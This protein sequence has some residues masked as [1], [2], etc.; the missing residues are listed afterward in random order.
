MQTF[1]DN[2][3]QG[4]IY[5]SPKNGKNLVPASFKIDRMFKYYKQQE[6]V[7]SFN[8]F[9]NIFQQSFLCSIFCIPWNVCN[10]YITKFIMKFFFR[11]VK[12]TDSRPL[13]SLYVLVPITQGYSVCSPFL[14][15]QQ[16]IQD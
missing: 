5:P 1:M 16:Y 13:A 10:S 4:F 12:K 11:G 15:L 7:E 14:G 9:Y 3:M 6:G 8:I 2:F